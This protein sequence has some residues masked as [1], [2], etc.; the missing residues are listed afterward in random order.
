MKKSILLP[1][2]FVLSIPFSFAQEAQPEIN[3]MTWHEAVAQHKNDLQ[4]Y[5][6]STV[7]TN[8]KVPPK[9][10]Y[11]DLYTS[12]CG[13]CKKM[14][15]STFKD[16]AIVSIMNKYY[17]P[18]KM[19]AEMSESIDFNGHTF[20]NPNPG[21][22]RSTHQFAASILD[23]QL[24]YPS[25]VILD[26][27]LERMVIYKGYLQVDDLLGIILFFGKNQNQKYQQQ[28]TKQIKQQLPPKQ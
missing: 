13:W 12:W 25:Y 9:K 10:M 22:S 20:V 15:Q 1:L 19:N 8:Q 26:E 21:K 2:F 23:Y 7:P 6:D 5:N 18:V 27:N 28:I 17:Y 24:S 4:T 14:D 11:I 3:W 16:P